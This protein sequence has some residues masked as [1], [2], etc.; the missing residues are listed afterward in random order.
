MISSCVLY[1]RKSDQT[2]ELLVALSVYGRMRRTRYLATP[3]SRSTFPAC[4]LSPARVAGLFYGYT[5]ARKMLRQIAYPM[6][7]WEIGRPRTIG[8]EGQGGI[9]ENE[10]EKGAPDQAQTPFSR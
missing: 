5:I 10:F 1:I 7:N 8:A 4:E 9:A 6:T 3:S 2:A